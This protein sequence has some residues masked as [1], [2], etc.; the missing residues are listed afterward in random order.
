MFVVVCGGGFDG[1]FVGIDRIDFEAVQNECRM[2]SVEPREGG[3]RT[4]VNGY[5]VP[6]LGVDLEESGGNFVIVGGAFGGEEAVDFDR[7]TNDNVERGWGDVADFVVVSRDGVF[8]GGEAR[9]NHI[10]AR[11]RIGGE[12]GR[13]F[14]GTR[15]RRRSHGDSITGHVDAIVERA[16]EKNRGAE[17]AWVSTEDD[18]YSVEG[19]GDRLAFFAEPVF[20]VRS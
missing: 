12:F 8:A 6:R 17:S 18:R 4:E 15:G 10:E 7:I 16:F 11:R 14:G 9:N 3:G 20:P 19:V 2:L 5:V 1:F 13:I